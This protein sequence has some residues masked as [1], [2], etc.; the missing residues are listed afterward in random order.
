MTAKRTATASWEGDLP[1]GHGTVTGASGALPVLGLTWAARTES[2]DGKTS[3][4]ELL[5]A[6]HAGC[7]AMALTATLGRAGKPS[8]RVSVRA[9]STF[10]KVGDAWKVTT[11]ELDVT[12]KVPGLSAGEFAE[13]AKRAEQGCPISGA[14]RGNVQIQL[15][16]RL[17]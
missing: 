14:I 9:T 13:I 10:D 12:A 1:K 17:A 16:A 11:M 15:N 5:A 2:S 8:E 6:A 3:P 7:F 4:E